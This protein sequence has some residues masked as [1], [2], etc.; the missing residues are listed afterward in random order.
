[1]MEKSSENNSTDIVE[2]ISKALVRLNESEQVLKYF[3]LRDIEDVNAKND[4]KISE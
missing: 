2:T 4:L 1:M 3:L